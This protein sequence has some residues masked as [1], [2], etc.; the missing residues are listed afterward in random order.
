MILLRYFYKAES[1]ALSKRSKDERMIMRH[2]NKIGFLVIFGFLVALL[3]AAGPDSVLA[4]EPLFGLGPHT[5]GQYSWALESEMKRGQAGWF[6]QLEL[7]YGLRPDIAFTVVAPYA[8]AYENRSAGFG[9]VLLRGKYRFYRRDYRGGSDAFALHGGV[10]LPTGDQAKLRGTGT[11][12]YFAG[13]SFGRESRRHYAFA[14]VRYQVNG[15]DNNLNR[16]NILNLE[17]AYGIRPLKLEYLQPD[18]VLLGELLGEFT[19]KNAL[20]NVGDPNTGG[21]VFSFAP[22][23]LFSYRNVM[24]KAAVKIPIMEKL[25]GIQ[26]APDAEVVVGIELHMPP[27]K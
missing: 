26:D 14:D 4:H 5:V 23:M 22:G 27:F 17:A 20:N 19:G 10:K 16:G 18:L 8:F 25:N 1:F 3:C 6:N 24:V 2:E 13:L 7:I 15:S 11:L 9:D 12:D 21:F